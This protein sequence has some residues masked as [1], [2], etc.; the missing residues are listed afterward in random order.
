MSHHHS[1]RPRRGSA[2]KTPRSRTLLLPCLGTLFALGGIALLT[3]YVADLAA[4]AHAAGGDE[5]QAWAAQE[6]DTLE[7]IVSP[8][9]AEG[10]PTMPSLCDQ[11]ASVGTGG[12]S[13]LSGIGGS[14]TGCFATHSYSFHTFV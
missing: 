10:A 9:R 2:G 8:P 3:A 14:S 13:S 6:L 1:S 11:I 12:F 5:T 4:P 7:S